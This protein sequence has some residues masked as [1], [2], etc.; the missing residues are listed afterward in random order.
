MNKV[1]AVRRVFKKCEVNPLKKVNVRKYVERREFAVFIVISLFFLVVSHLSAA[2]DLLKFEHIGSSLGFPQE[3]NV[4]YIY[5][6]SRGFLWFGTHNGVNKFDGYTFTVFQHKPDDPNSPGHRIIRCIYEDLEGT[7]WF[8]TESSL[9]KFDRGND[10]FS[11]YR[12]PIKGLT[13]SSYTPVYS[14]IESPADPGILYLGTMNGLVRFDKKMET[15]TTVPA[16]SDYPA[17]QAENLAAAILETSPGI[18]WISSFNGLFKYDLKTKVITKYKHDPEVPGSLSSDYVYCLQKSSV[19]PGLLW[20]GTWKGLNKFDTKKETFTHYRH[21]PLNPSSLSHDVIR[22]ICESPVERGILWLGTFG[23]GI[24]KFD[25]NTGKCL[26]FKHNSNDINSPGSDT[27]LSVYQDLSGVLWAGTRFMGLYRAD[28]TAR[29]FIHYHVRPNTQEGLSD[30]LVFSILESPSMPG[31]FWIGTADGLNR[32]DRETGIFTL[33]RSKPGNPNSL[34]SSD[35]RQVYECPSLPGILWIG[36]ELRE[37]CKFDPKK[38]SYV[39]YEHDPKN[40]NTPTPHLASTFHESL[41]HPG[42]L[43]IATRGG[44]ITRMD[45]AEETFTTYLFDSEESKIRHKNQ[46]LDIY[47]SRG[48]PGIL[49][50]AS[51]SSGLIRFD[52]KAGKFAR[53]LKTPGDTNSILCVYG[54]PQNPGILWLGA[55]RGLVKFD[56]KSGLSVAFPGFGSLP[57]YIVKGILQDKRKNLWLSTDNGLLK[58][59]PENGKIKRYDKRDG[60]QGNE[61]SRA[62]CKSRSGE[63]FFGGFDGFNSFF[64]S[65]IKENPYVP[66]IVITG[67]RVFNKPVKA[68][69]AGRDGRIILKQNIS[70]EKQVQLS[71]KVRV[72]TFEFAALSYSLPEKNSFACKMEGFDKEW[73]D[74]GTRRSATYTGLSPG[75]YIFRVK[76]SN[77]DGIWNEEG[78]SIRVIITPPWWRTIWAYALYIILLAAAV[79]TLNRWQRARL[80]QREQDKAKVREAELRAQA[81]DARTRAVEAENRRKS[82]ELEGARKLQL[83]MLPEKVPEQG[84]FDI[85]VYMNTAHE[86]GGDYYDF[87]TDEKGILITAIGDATGHGLKAGHMVSIMKGILLSGDL[88]RQL[89]M[90]AFFNKSTRTI[91]QMHLENLFMALT[92]V[93][94]KNNRAD[95]TSAGMPPV[96]LLREAGGRVEDILLKAPPLGAFNDFSYPAKEVELSPGDTLLLLSDGLPEL[97]D[98]KGRMFGY[99]RVKRIFEK[100]VG[101]TPEQIIAHLVDAAE[102]WLDGKAR[103]DDITF[104]VLKVKS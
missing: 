55:I 21:D 70:E 29:K 65:R 27:I 78:A 87:F 81:A 58:F 1:A 30:N 38:N 51:Y 76:G 100:A 101:K 48:E 49:W 26:R 56:I 68:G 90:A 25:A 80:I 41:D 57:G 37:I 12:T 31:I 102:T 91:K 43:W 8:G 14:I 2:D 22:T 77:N 72:F 34:S 97:F 16:F 71:Y 33:Y 83:S 88:T 73:V 52:T 86:V 11:H 36:T 66:P 18:L 20:I 82:Q 28:T 10:T 39:K 79:I 67:F 44:G 92:L 103:D 62:T 63:M 45:I 46:I 64:P 15:F 75:S 95:I 61:F 9:D 96:Y 4:L 85:A 5:Q 60:L 53:Y 89:D 42:V 19:E 74:C 40:E 59:N 93:K 98:R 84:N 47:E 54:P 24:N 17:G 23:G 6:D 35:I 7:L 3:G 32:F 99:S 94:L 50:L 69:T 104:V 13:S